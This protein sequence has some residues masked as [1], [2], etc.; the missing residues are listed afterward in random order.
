MG[1]RDSKTRG[2]VYAAAAFLM[3]G[4]LP[5]YW[6]ILKAVPAFEILMHRIFWSFVFM[7]LIFFYRGRWAGLKA[8]L[9]KRRKVAAIIAAAVLVS[10]NWGIYIWAVNADHVVDASL[11]YYIN[12]L[13]SVVL[14][15]VVLKE[16]L[17]FWQVVS[18]M[19]AFFG[20]LIITFQYG[21]I[22]WIALSL[23]VT[24]GLYG[25]VKKMAGIESTLGLTLETFI[26]M[27]F[28]LGYL[29]YLHLQGQGSFGISPKITLTLAFAGAATA[30]PLLWFAQ[31]AQ[32]IPL[33]AVG[34]IQYLTPTIMLILGVVL[35][36][37]PFT[38][39]HLLGFACIWSALALF[40]L[41]QIKRFKGYEPKWLKRKE[42]G[43]RNLR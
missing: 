17:N 12:P 21:R 1:K 41:S 43:G 28:A 30:V 33:S 40:S 36:G 20:V 11:G 3:W 10:L 34:F 26:L 14:G 22:P 13:L 8:V 4:F 9:K 37:E 42:Y 32:M 2:A 39:L 6:K 27:P 31:A 19:L 35:Y 15:M 16:R 23:A 38:G 5:L 7:L 18:L 29:T 24:F 25:L